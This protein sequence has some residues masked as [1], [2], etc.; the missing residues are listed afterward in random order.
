MSK[1][2][3]YRKEEIM[4]EIKKLLRNL[5]LEK[6]KLKQMV[7]INELINEMKNHAKKIGKSI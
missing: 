4:N 6:D 7:I 3:H 5:E 2:K 1:Q